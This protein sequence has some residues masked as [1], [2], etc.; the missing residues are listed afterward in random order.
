[1]VIVLL[2]GKLGEIK[3]RKIPC[4]DTPEAGARAR[5]G[6]VRDEIDPSPS[7]SKN[8]QDKAEPQTAELTQ[9]PEGVEGRADQEAPLKKEAES[10]SDP[11]SLTRLRKYNECLSSIYRLQSVAVPR[12][13]QRTDQLY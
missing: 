7:R 8:S 13:D 9:L 6:G 2:Q 11:K 12:T 5:E 10:G 1:M 3:V 4:P